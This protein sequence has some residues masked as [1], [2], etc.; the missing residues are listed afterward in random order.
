MVQAIKYVVI[1]PVRDEEEHIESTLKSVSGQTILPAEWVIVDDGSTDGTARILDQYAAQ[2]P[3]VQVI[4]RTNRGFRKSGAGV[5]EAFNDGYR[6][7]RGN[8]WEFIVKL[9][10]D[11][12][13]ELNYFERCFEHFQAEPRLG[14]GGGEI[15]HD[16]A[17]TLQVEDNPRFHVRGATKIYR[18][19][20]WEAIGGLRQVPGWDT[21][22]EVKANMLGW[23]SYSLSDLRLVHHRP[24]G[25]ADGL[26]KNRVKHGLACYATGY[27]PLFVAASCLSRLTQKPYILGSAAIFWG[28][29]KG[30]FT[31]LRRMRDK[32]MIGYLQNQQLRRLCGLESIWK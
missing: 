16:H 12:T 20:C 21:I 4:H 10:G 32:Q 9:D 19:E 3:W 29:V 26:L 24:T 25:L 1:T 7:L 23:K 6:A 5:V 2:L 18:R 14:I 27:H 15:C 17:G 22:D 8:D 30:R 28:F 11:L 13:F 31:D